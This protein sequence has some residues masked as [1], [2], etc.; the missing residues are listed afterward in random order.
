MS[1][2]IASVRFWLK[3][4]RSSQSGRALALLAAALAKAPASVCEEEAGEWSSGAQ[5]TGAQPPGR[6]QSRLRSDAGAQ[7]W[8]TATIKP[9]KIS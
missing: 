7:R 6:A 9:S 8:R 3:A 2:S 4:L 5:L 1:F